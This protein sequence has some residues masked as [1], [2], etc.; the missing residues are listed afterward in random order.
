MPH[1]QY[2][3]GL[4]S[5]EIDGHKFGGAKSGVPW[6]N[7]STLSRAPCACNLHAILLKDIISKQHF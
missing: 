7:S 3:T 2:T 1:T 5:G 4:K 6:Q